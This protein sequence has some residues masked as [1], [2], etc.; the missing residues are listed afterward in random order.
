MLHSVGLHRPPRSVDPTAL[1]PRMASR[2]RAERAGRLAQQVDERSDAELRRRDELIASANHALRTPLCSIMGYTEMLLAGDAGSLTEDQ[3]LMLQRVT[4]SAER[5]A[6]LVE[7][8][9]QVTTECVSPTRPAGLAG[10]VL[11]EVAVAESRPVEPDADEG[12]GS[13]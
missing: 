5:L 12:D 2:V 6:S 11:E 8:L 10:A 1:A 7:Q 13:A 3:V 9:L 4:L